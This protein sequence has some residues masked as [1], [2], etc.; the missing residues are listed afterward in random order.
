MT[1]L[2]SI[3]TIF[4][5]SRYEETAKWMAIIVADPQGWAEHAKREGTPPV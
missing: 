1:G 2:W 5:G 3:G 4:Y